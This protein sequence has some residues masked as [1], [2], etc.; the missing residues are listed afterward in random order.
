[1]IIDTYEEGGCFWVNGSFVNL[2]DYKISILDTG[3]CRSDLTYDV[4][5]VWDGNFFRL[6][7]HLDRFVRGCEKLK[8]L[9]GPP[10][11]EIRHILT[12]C[13]RLSG[14][15]N[16]YVEM[17][18]ARGLVLPHSRD[19]RLFKN[20]FY[21]CS[22]PYVWLFPLEKRK[23]GIDLIIS[24]ETLRISPQAVDPT[25]KNFHWGDLVRG[26]IEAYEADADTAV[27]C[28]EHDN[29]T[30]GPGFNLFVVIDG[31]LQTP[32]SG[33]LHGITRRT[34]LELARE[35]GIPFQETN[36]GRGAL[37]DATEIF[38]TSTAGGIYPVRS[39]D[40]RLLCKNSKESITETLARAYWN[41]HD[42]EEWC[43]PISFG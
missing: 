27:L 2:E 26:L 8:M 1:M 15:K 31:I 25:I 17:I 43:T 7:D 32:V 9:N 21:A 40:G 30:E 35:L 33:V 11:D 16:A 23:A 41:S 42:R 6:E 36:I 3:F 28:D 19:P 5:S 29:L 22:V 24:K 39:V 37:V 14:L 12:D 34:V 38:L 13:V 18:L 4:V 10:R 20:T